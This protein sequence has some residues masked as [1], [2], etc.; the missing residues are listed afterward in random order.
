[1]FIGSAHLNILLPAVEPLPW[2]ALP[3]SPDPCDMMTNPGIAGHPGSPATLRRLYT[4]RVTLLD[5]I[6]A[7]CSSRFSAPPLACARCRQRGACTLLCLM[8]FLFSFTVEKKETKG[9]AKGFCSGPC[10]WNKTMLV[11]LTK[12]GQETTGR[13]RTN[14]DKYIAVRRI[15]RPSNK[16]ILSLVFPVRPRI[17]KG[18][19]LNILSA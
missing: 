3:C 13:R 1:M 5:A 18:H 14:T 6:S 16:P 17:G 12:L 15:Q 2:P 19:F 4:Q 9:P 10:S 11:R 7:L 8:Y